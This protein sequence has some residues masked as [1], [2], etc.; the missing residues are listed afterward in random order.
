MKIADTHSTFTEAVEAYLSLADYL[1]DEDAPMVT[2]LVLVAKELDTNGI[3][4]RLLSDYGIAYR[5]L[6]KKAADNNGGP[7]AHQS[8]LDAL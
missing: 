6:A 2:A 8:F 3:S 7:D 1:T 5:T 4:T